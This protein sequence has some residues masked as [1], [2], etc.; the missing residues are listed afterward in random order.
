MPAVHAV[1]AVADTVAAA[2]LLHRHNT[3]QVSGSCCDA[4]RGCVQVL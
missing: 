2:T 1:H 3:K 4:R